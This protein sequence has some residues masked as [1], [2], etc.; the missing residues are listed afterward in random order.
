[1]RVRVCMQ[2]KRVRGN[3]SKS[4]LKIICYIAAVIQQNG[5]DTD[6]SCHESQLVF[7]THSKTVEVLFLY[8]FRV[9]PLM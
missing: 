2:K 8:D 6:L 7:G 4:L 1:M 3:L 5:P 9:F